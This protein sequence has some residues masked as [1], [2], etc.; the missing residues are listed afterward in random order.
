MP[1]TGD[2]G[3]VQAMTRYLDGLGTHTPEIAKRA[4][5]PIQAHAR[6]SYAQGQS[7]SGTRWAPRKIDGAVAYQRPASGVTFRGE[8]YAIVGDAEEVLKWPQTSTRYP[9]EI[10]PKT[11]LPDAWDQAIEGAAKAVL[12]EKAPE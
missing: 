9:R 6:A 4:A 3:L 1:L 2:F 8:G 11:A 10:F 12:E 5:G 7:P